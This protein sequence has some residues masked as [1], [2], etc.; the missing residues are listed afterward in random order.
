MPPRYERH[1]LQRNSTEEIVFVDI[2]GISNRP[3]STLG[4]RDPLWTTE[5]FRIPPHMVYDLYGLGA[6]VDTFF[7][8]QM[9]ETFVNYMIPLDHFAGT[10]IGP[11]T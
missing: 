5:I 6:G 8:S 9:P 10:I 11:N 1:I 7:V 3:H 2:S 4:V